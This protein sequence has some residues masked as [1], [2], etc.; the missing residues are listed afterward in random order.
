MPL[1]LQ[2]KLLRFLQ[3]REIERLG[4]REVIQV[5]VRVV[6]ATNK[7]LEEMVASG[8]FREDLF[9]RISEI[10]IDI[11]PL[12]ARQSDRILLARH[13]LQK[14][15]K[16]LEKSVNTYSPEAITAIEAYQWPGNIREMENKI[17]RAVI[18]CDD[19]LISAHD[20]GLAEGSIPCINLR[21]VR[22]EADKSAINNALAF[23]AGNISAAAKL[24]G[25][26]RPTLYDL[27]KK[28]QIQIDSD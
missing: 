11:P 18:M 6:C 23:S 1:A 12:R 4:G 19:K 28:Y 20:L 27:V 10:V 5:D 21:Q 26:T 14:F 24:L 3:E 22:L 13:L 8:E 2:A 16:E 7:P 25:V 17:R 9:Y 15:S